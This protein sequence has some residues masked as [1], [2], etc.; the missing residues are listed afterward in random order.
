MPS[1]I[2]SQIYKAHRVRSESANSTRPLASYRFTGLDN[3]LRL[4]HVAVVLD[5]VDI[6]DHAFGAVIV[7]RCSA[8]LGQLRETAG[9][10]RWP[11]SLLVRAFP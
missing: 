5:G 6:L 10:I 3:H 8:Q 7:R 11:Y 4:V 2:A 1:L 9:K